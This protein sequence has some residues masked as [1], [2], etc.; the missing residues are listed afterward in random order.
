MKNIIIPALFFATL[1]LIVFRNYFTGE[2]FVGTD[3]MGPPTDMSVMFQENSYFSAWRDMPSLG[4]INF[5]SVT[6]GS[7][8][9]FLQNI[10]GMSAADVFRM[11]IIGSFWLAGFA[12]YGC[13]YGITKNRLAA[14][15]AGVVYLFSQVYLSQITENHN[16]FI[17]GYALFPILFYFF[18]KSFTDKKVLYAAFVP[19]LAFLMGTIGAPHTILITAIFLLLFTFI[20][21]LLPALKNKKEFPAALTTIFIGII[22]VAVLVLPMAFSKFADGGMYSLSTV[23][24][25]QDAQSFSSYSLLHSFLM[26]STENTFIDTTPALGSWSLI[27]SL[28]P[29]IYVTGI[30]TPVLA[31]YSL[32][33]KKERHLLLSLAIP[34]VIFICIACGPNPPFG[35][36][37]TF[38]FENVPMVDS[39][40]VFSRF[41][42]LTAFAYAMMI[43]ILITHAKEVRN[44]PTM[45]KGTWKMLR[46]EVLN[47]KVLAVVISFCMIFSSSAILSGEVKSF[48]ISSTYSEPFEDLKGVDGDFRVLTL[49]FA[50]KYYDLA[51]D[52][53]DGFPSSL[54]PDVGMF[55]P[56]ISGKMYAFGLETEDYWSFV[57]SALFGEAFGYKDI[58]ELLGGTADVRFIVS[59]AYTRD[60]EESIFASL[61]GMIIWKDYD[62]GA[63]IFENDNWQPRVHAADSSMFVIGS[64]QYLVGLAGMGIADLGGT[65]VLPEYSEENLDEIIDI[66]GGVAIS[67][68]TDYAIEISNLRDAVIMLSPYGNV[69]TNDDSS[70]WKY[71]DYF[72]GQGYSPYPGASTSSKTDLSFTVEASE[73]GNYSLWLDLMYSFDFGIVKVSVDGQEVARVDCRSTFTHS[74]WTKIADLNLEEGKHTITLTPTGPG[75]VCVQRAL[76]TTA[77]EF[78][79]AVESSSGMLADLNTSIVVPASLSS[80]W[81]GTYL[82]WLGDLGYGF[83]SSAFFNAV[84]AEGKQVILKPEEA[85]TLG[86]VPQSTAGVEY[87]ISLDLSGVDDTAAV[88][89]EIWTDGYKKPHKVVSFAGGDLSNASFTYLSTGDPFSVVVRSVGHEDVF[90]NSMTVSIDSTDASTVIEV[91]STGDYILRIAGEGGKAYL[92]GREIT[93]SENNGYLEAAVHLEK[94]KH[95]IAVENMNIYGVAIIP[96]ETPEEQAH[97]EISYVH[98]DSISYTVNTSSDKP[99]WLMVCDSYSTKWVATIDGVPL[100]HV[101]ANSMVNAYYVP[102]GDHTIE[103]NYTGQET[104]DEMLIIYAVVVPAAMVLVVASVWYLKRRESKKKL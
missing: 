25:I 16:L 100:A 102:A 6:L 28:W 63:I 78:N 45:L 44:M 84:T 30:V 12:M 98:K 24:A 33:V 19:I 39:I 22:T 3:G 103:I 50:Q 26:F 82:P 31:F 37:F 73:K 54:M 86:K 66:L 47:P 27:H 34:A 2:F 61:V 52:R 96:S 95:T 92:D 23:W 79:S 1:T 29:L 87:N 35:N 10:L 56:Y 14:V 59:Q 99:F 17:L 53:Y 49:P 88:L 85:F 9:Y 42:L 8:Y 11:S 101:A 67:S 51:F 57:G 83:G 60:S 69:H 72:Y 15:T 36:V 104:Y 70:E 40:R 74:A 93:L 46:K 65:N 94:G 80:L 90:V 32:K 55:S 64:R 75:M 58:S 18:Y 76:F 97:P 5:P 71:N 20:Y 13:A 89:V 77:D 68:I 38:L 91:P 4:H 7:I 48:D 41:H 43:A 21:S 62:S 81:E